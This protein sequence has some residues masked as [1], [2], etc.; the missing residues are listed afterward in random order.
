MYD[1]QE[2]NTLCCNKIMLINYTYYVN[3]KLKVIPRTINNITLKPRLKNKYTASAGCVV[4]N[5][6]S[7]YIWS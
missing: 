5:N 3:Q 2:S 6:L 1:I 7:I 4:A